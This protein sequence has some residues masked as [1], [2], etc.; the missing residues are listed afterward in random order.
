MK[1]YSLKT[2]LAL[3]VTGMLILS[4]CGKKEDTKPTPVGP[5]ISGFTATAT[6]S[7]TTSGDTLKVNLGATISFGLTVG[8]GNT[9]ED[10]NLKQF[11][12]TKDLV[13]VG[14]LGSLKDTTYTEAAAKQNVTYAL[15]DVVSATTSGVYKYVFTISDYN[16]KTS[17]K[18]YYV[19]SGTPCTI[20]V[21]VT[22]VAADSLTVTVAGSGLTSG[23]YEYSFDGGTTWASTTTYMFTTVG[24]K[25]IQVR[26]AGTP[27]CASNTTF[28]VKGKKVRTN[29][30]IV[31]GAETAS[32]PSLYDAD[33][34]MTY[35]Y[36]A[37]TAQPTAD[38]AMHTGGTSSTKFHAPSVSGTFSYSGWTAAQRLATKFYGSITQ[39][40]YNAVTTN[41]DLTGLVTG[42]STT[43]SPALATNSGFAFE[44]VNSSGTVIAR[45]VV[46]VTAFTSGANGSATFNV[47]LYTL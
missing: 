47:K 28:M 22:S 17:T 16:S 10:K 24:S 34:N 35:S 3:F 37:T 25:N 18:T 38:F 15:S 32:S 8:K 20:G 46:W 27:T 31:L 30:S 4:S 11:K 42:G 41:A 9:S 1:S 43:A 26:Q 12:V 44:T 33:A 5:N 40:Q 45:G 23:T 39:T 21:A 7:G 6:P 36:S 13:G 14:S 29:S 19:K 2:M